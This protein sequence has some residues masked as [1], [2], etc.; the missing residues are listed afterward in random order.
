[1]QI[2]MR[3]N[4]FPRIPGILVVFCSLIWGSVV[5]QVPVEV[6]E[7]GSKQRQSSSES[8][9]SNEIMV[10]MYLQLEALQSEVQNLRG[11][12]EEQSY[13][14]RRM[15]TE[16]RDRYLDSDSRLSEINNQV[17][18]F[19][20]SQQAVGIQLL[21][22]SSQVPVIADNSNNIGSL[23]D[24]S[25][26]SSLLDNAIAAGATVAFISPQSEQELYREALNLLL[27]DEAFSES[28]SQ[29]QQYIDRYPDGRYFTN[30]LYWQG[31]SMELAGRYPQAMGV[32]RRLINEYPTDAK[33]P[34][35]ILRLGIIYREIG[36][37]NQAAAQWRRISELYPESASEIE[38]ANEYLSKISTN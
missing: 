6:V 12:V 18:S 16:Q 35:A 5:A 31:A 7:A 32:L 2:F 11:L 26:A 9:G 1:M 28:I 8:N 27:E 10:N 15:Q 14:V 33:A 22:S 25:P 37:N 3:V 19:H 24:Q 13:Q 30:A 21:S 17:Q 4:L 38:I 23:Q 29:F 20:S 34:T 36:D